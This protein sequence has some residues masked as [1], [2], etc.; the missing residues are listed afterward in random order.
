MNYI[1]ATHSLPRSASWEF[2]L[3]H[4]GQISA[5]ILRTVLFTKQH[6]TLRVSY[7]KISSVVPVVYVLEQFIVL[8]QTDFIQFYDTA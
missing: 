3:R 8:L 7:W 5:A 2:G 6:F 1:L 4:L